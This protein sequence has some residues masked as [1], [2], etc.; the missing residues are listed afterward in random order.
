MGEQNS[1][2]ET[3]QTFYWEEK[4]SSSR[5]CRRSLL[6]PL[7]KTGHSQ[8]RSQVCWASFLPLRWDPT[9]GKDPPGWTQPLLNQG[10]PCW[11]SLLLEGQWRTY[12]CT[13]LWIISQVVLL[14]VGVASPSG[15][16]EKSLTQP[17]SNY[18][19]SHGN[20]WQKLHL[21]GV[22]KN[23]EGLT[24]SK[25]CLH[26]WGLNLRKSL[27]H[28]NFFSNLCTRVAIFQLFPLS[29]GVS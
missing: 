5:L 19:K 9:Q 17:S 10:A 2:P 4:K 8:S 25:C 20:D 12:S 3:I 6:D 24:S 1:L 7:F 27:K 13:Y 22:F 16:R 29:F 18:C 26:P 11:R 28:S 14:T 15:R 23:P 21:S